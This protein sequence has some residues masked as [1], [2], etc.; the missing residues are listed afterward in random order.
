MKILIAV[1]SITIMFGNFSNAQGL[2]CVDLFQAKQADEITNYAHYLEQAVNTLGQQYIDVFNRINKADK[3][4]NFNSELVHVADLNDDALDLTAELFISYQNISSLEEKQKLLPYQNMLISF[5]E[6]QGFTIEAI[7]AMIS[8]KIN[9]LQ[10]Q[11]QSQLLPKRSIGFL[12]QEYDPNRY[13]NNNKAKNILAGEKLPTIGFVQNETKKRN[14]YRM[15]FIFSVEIYLEDLKSGRI[16]KPKLKSL[17]F[18]QDMSKENTHSKQMP[19]IGFIQ[20]DNAK[21][22]VNYRGHLNFDYTHAIFFVDFD[23]PKIGFY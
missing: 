19:S 20:R 11:Q 5:F 7:R 13:G 8:A 22:D 9:F 17:G 6:K 1:F 12:N 10:Q 23:K 15:P 4:K 14:V 16:P 21:D 18:I 2:K 3:N